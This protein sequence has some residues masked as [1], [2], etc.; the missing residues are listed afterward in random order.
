MISKKVNE[1][2]AGALRL[3]VAQKNKDVFNRFHIWKTVV[4]LNGAKVSV[5]K[6]IVSKRLKKGA[7]KEAKQIPKEPE[8]IQKRATMFCKKR[9]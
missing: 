6:A 2:I 5:T 7:K 3:P 4:M 8:V 1:S 9:P